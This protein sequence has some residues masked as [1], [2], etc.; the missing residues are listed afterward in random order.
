MV[1]LQLF[2]PSKHTIAPTFC[3]RDLAMNNKQLAV[4]I[5]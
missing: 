4:G 3:L 1:F 2:L 5:P